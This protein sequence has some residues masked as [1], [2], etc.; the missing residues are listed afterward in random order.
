MTSGLDCHLDHGEITLK[1]MMQS[2]NWVQFMLDL[3]MVAEPGSKFEYCSG[4]MHL[5]ASCSLFTIAPSPAY[6]AL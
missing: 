6:I 1:E 5:C 4:G 3:P 2:K